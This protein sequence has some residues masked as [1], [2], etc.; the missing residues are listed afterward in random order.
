MARPKL[1]SADTPLWLKLILYPYQVA[2]SLSLAVILITVM[3]VTFAMGTIIE[4]A[5]NTPVA[6]FVVYQTWWFNLIGAL[7]AVNIFCAAAIRYP[8]KKHQTGFVVT[9]IGLLT[10]IFGL[11]LS[12]WHGIDAQLP[13]YEGATENYAFS[14]DK[15]FIKLTIHNMEDGPEDAKSHSH[16]AAAASHTGGDLSDAHGD[17]KTVT[18][19]FKPGPFNWEDY[20]W[21]FPNLFTFAGRHSAGDV[22]YNRDGVKV[23]VLDFYSD[24]REVLA[25]EISV[26]ISTP[27][28]DVTTDDGRVVKGKPMWVPATLNVG[29]ANDKLTFPYGIPTR[30]R[31]GGG[32]L[33][34]S[35]SSGA[36]ETRGF[37]NGGPRGETGEKG[38]VVLHLEGK[39]LRVNVDDKLEKGRFPLEGT[40]Y[41]AEVA[42]FWNKST[43]R[44]DAGG[45]LTFEGSATEPRPVSPIVK[46]NVFKKGGN[47]RIS[48]LTLFAVNPEYN[49]YDYD[50]G[51]F[52][53][54]WYEHRGLKFDELQK[55]GITSWIHILQD[56]DGK[57]LNYR[58]WNRKKIVF[59]K[60]L[61][62]N[63]AKKNAVDAFKMPA[64]ELKMYVEELVP[65]SKPQSI[66]MPRKFDRQPRNRV[67]QPAAKLRLTVDDASEE[68]WLYTYMGDPDRDPTSPG[69][70][71]SLL[72]DDNKK[73]ATVIM[74][75]EAVDIG[76][77]VR[78]D[79]FERKLD[80][81]SSQAA[82]FS[83]TV[84]FLDAEDNTQLHRVALAG[85]NA[86]AIGADVKEPHDVTC[87]VGEGMLYVTAG[88]DT[89]MSIQ[90]IDLNKNE[91]A[92]LIE[93][94]D[95]VRPRAIAAGGNRIFWVDTVNSPRGDIS[96]IRFADADGKPVELPEQNQSPLL[97]A[98]SRGFSHSAITAIDGP[99]SA[100]AVDVKAKKLYWIDNRNEAIGRCDF[101]GSG[102]EEKF[103]DRVTRAG[104]IAIS[105]KQ[106]KLYWTIPSEGVLRSASLED[107]KSNSLLLSRTEGL[108]PQQI[109]ISEDG[110]LYWTEIDSRAVQV[111]PATGQP[112]VK[113][114]AIM[115]VKPGSGEE[116]SVVA[117]DT[118]DNP[119]GLAV[120]KSANNSAASGVYWVQDAVFRRDV[121][122]TMNAPVEFSDPANGRWY[123]LFQE[124]FDGPKRPGDPEYEM[125][126]PAGSPKDELYRS[127][128]SVNYDPG[129]GIRSAGCLL[130]VLG[131]GLM[132]YMRAYFFKRTTSPAARREATEKKEVAAGIAS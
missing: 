125:Y 82:H 110:F 93:F 77:R 65:A 100:I 40:G 14:Q 72:S 11:T 122:I 23:E 123:R 33:I 102:T 57:S 39:T 64:G 28:P 12:R 94:K 95:L 116:P 74:P 5:W 109:A 115:R 67:K 89:E 105:S 58:Y 38:Q 6:Q 45:R 43:P 91:V 30:E 46:V 54:F 10:L 120:Y 8:W 90:R 128:L 81:G 20:K 76:F 21:K 22:L 79:K 78:L 111:D 29:K 108:Q 19:D 83:S 68:F 130:V 18:V 24:S 31:R 101:D 106:N 80:P 66:A 41:E 3:V 55:M 44:A 35:I 98:L 17:S 7:L 114:H 26:K 112:G 61:P 73:M 15:Q 103:V 87:D 121:W 104:G 127:V 70:F 107:G 4:A 124:A 71:H 118:I 132:F 92:P 32:A 113:Q 56:A 16:A 36:E 2:A 131:I 27:A 60:E 51:I 25:P 85:G 62:I 84:D 52:G 126:V 75:M 50:N 69:L 9:H 49:V 13:V 96:V 117:T 63:G 48:Q 53:E 42:G 99:I 119:A 59:A 47:K 88:S 97:E 1:I 34:F 129:R 86:T 37:L